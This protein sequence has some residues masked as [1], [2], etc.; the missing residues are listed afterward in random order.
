MCSKHGHYSR[1]RHGHRHKHRRRSFRVS[2]EQYTMMLGETVKSIHERNLRDRIHIPF[3]EVQRLAAEELHTGLVRYSYAAPIDTAATIVS[4]SRVPRAEPGE[5]IPR[6]SSGGRF[7][8]PFDDLRFV[9]D[10]CTGSVDDFDEGRERTDRVERV[11]VPPAVAAY[12]ETTLLKLNGRL[13]RLKDE[14][15][16]QRHR[17][18]R[19]GGSLEDFREL[20]RFEHEIAELEKELRTERT[21]EEGSPAAEARSREIV[22]WALTHG[23][24]W[25]TAKARLY[26][27]LAQ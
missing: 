2:P 7:S 6:G 22:D 20:E 21:L 27:H 10:E 17:L 24:D 12:G 4:R 11:R 3:E 19:F 5:G 9:D 1:S 25:A 26:P 13:E 8:A 15:R 18:N 23:T 16:H 14:A